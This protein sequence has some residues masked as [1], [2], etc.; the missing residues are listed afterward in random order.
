[1]IYDAAKDEI[2]GCKRGSLVWFHEKRHQWQEKT[3]GGVSFLTFLWQWGIT[4]SLVA[5]LTESRIAVT[6]ALINWYVWVIW[7]LALE[8]DAWIYAIRKKV[9]RNEEGNS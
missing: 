5:L 4:F 7:G 8:I 3:F 9:M 1:M 6:G 2:K